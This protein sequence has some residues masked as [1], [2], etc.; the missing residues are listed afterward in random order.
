MEPTIDRLVQDFERGRLT[1][2]E[3]VTHVAVVATALAMSGAQSKAHAE[4][5]STF[6]AT[7]LNHI[8][9]NT[10]DIAVSR[11]FYAKHLGMTVS[12]EGANNCFMTCGD[13]FVAF[14]KSQES[15]MNH[16]CYSVENFDVKKAETR[17]RAEGLAPRREG[18]RIYFQDP[19][20]LTVQLASGT[21]AP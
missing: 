12:R 16:Y 13:N 9:L 18:N 17:L 10:P 21:H 1:R 5:S 19:H 15:S 20:G 3:L 6:K 7:S 4:E 2:R 14:F 11:D 8:A